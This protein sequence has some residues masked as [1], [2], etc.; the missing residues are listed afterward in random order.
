MSNQVRIVPEGMA[1][2]VKADPA[3]ANKEV[4]DKVTARFVNNEE[5]S[6]PICLQSDSPDD[7]QLRMSDSPNVERMVEAEANGIPVIACLKH[8]L[9]M[10]IR[11]KE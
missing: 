9:V 3:I 5:G 2:I 11:N 1:P 7:V 10:P 4:I 8:N 6:C